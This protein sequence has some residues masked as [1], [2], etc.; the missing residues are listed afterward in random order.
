MEPGKDREYP[1][2]VGKVRVW[3]WRDKMTR[4]SL[5]RGPLGHT[6]HAIARE[7]VT[8]VKRKKQSSLTLPLPR[9]VTRAHIGNGKPESH[10]STVLKKAKGCD[11]SGSKNPTIFYPSFPILLS[12][13]PE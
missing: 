3:L 9:R 6:S 5:Y 13:N 10:P 2:I 8:Y 4:T 7:L 11:T 12:H 1:M